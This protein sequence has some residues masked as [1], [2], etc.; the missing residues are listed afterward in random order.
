MIINAVKIVDVE[1]AGADP[2][3]VGYIAY[4]HWHPGVYNPHDLAEGRTTPR[5][6]VHKFGLLAEILL[7]AFLM[8]IEKKILKEANIGTTR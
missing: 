3:D 1:L 7:H 5:V 6:Y 2:D 8:R 4:V